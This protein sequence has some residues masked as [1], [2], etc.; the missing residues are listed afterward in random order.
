MLFRSAPETLANPLVALIDQPGIGEVLATGTPLV[1]PGTPQTPAP[2][3]L[4]GADTETVR[5]EFSKGRQ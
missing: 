1:Q 3:P 4:L 5:R 2:A